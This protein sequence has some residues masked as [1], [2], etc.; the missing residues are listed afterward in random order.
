[1]QMHIAQLQYCYKKVGSLS[2]IW[3]QKIISPLAKELD[4]NSKELARA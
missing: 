3:H 2:P 4:K 1:M